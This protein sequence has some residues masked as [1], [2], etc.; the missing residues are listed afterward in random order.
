MNATGSFVIGFFFALTAVGGRLLV[1]PDWRLFV[2][3]GFCGGFTTFSS[4]SLQ[5]LTLLRDGQERLAGLNAFGSLALCMLTV[6]L[7]FVCA[8]ALNPKPEGGPRVSGGVAAAGGRTRC[9]FKGNQQDPWPPARGRRLREPGQIRGREGLDQMDGKAGF[10]A[11]GGS[12]HSVEPAH[13]N[14]VPWPAAG[15]LQA[16]EQLPTVPVGQSEIAQEHVERLLVGDTQGRGRVSHDPRLVTE[17]L[18]KRAQDRAK[19]AVIFDDEQAEGS[20]HGCWFAT[21]VMVRLRDFP[22][23]PMALGGSPRAHPPREP[24]PAGLGHP[25]QIPLSTLSSRAAPAG[26]ATFPLRMAPGVTLRP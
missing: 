8:A 3:V 19:I 18:G 6:W 7:G 23:E 26:G 17:S 4:L 15:L 12:G 10:P 5:T 2:T 14:R 11:P 16:S 25:L 9:P 13:G 1:S 22:G 20:V 21:T 24:S